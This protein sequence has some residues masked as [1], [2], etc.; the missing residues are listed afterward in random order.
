VEGRANQGDAEARG[1]AAELNWTPAKQS[2]RSKLDVTIAYNHLWIRGVLVTTACDQYAQEDCGTCSH[3]QRQGGELG[4]A[5]LA[6]L[7]CEENIVPGN[8][9]ER[10]GPAW[11]EA[12]QPRRRCLKK[13][14]LEKSTA[15]ASLNGCLGPERAKPRVRRVADLWH[16]AGFLSLQSGPRWDPPWRSAASLHGPQRGPNDIPRKASTPKPTSPRD[17]RSGKDG[18]GF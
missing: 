14:H 13:G 15:A 7:R 5:A 16:M 1:N 6:A 9:A 8:R 10:I 3:S 4:G 2:W 12:G 17:I 18:N 11:S